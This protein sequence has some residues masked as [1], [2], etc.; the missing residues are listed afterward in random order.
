MAL[1]A[2]VLDQLD[3]ERLRDLQAAGKIGLC[4]KQGR[5]GLAVEKGRCGS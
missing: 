5:N 1:Q 3:V 4:I 2:A